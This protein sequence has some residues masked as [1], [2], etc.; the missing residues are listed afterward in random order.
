MIENPWTKVSKEE[1]YDNPWIK[2]T[3]HQVINAAGKAGIYG[4]V[5]FKNL[6]IGI[7]PVDREGYS[8]LVG[9]Y[10]FPLEAYSWEIPEGGGK[11]HLPPL[12][13]AKR[14][15]KEETGITASKWTE[16]QRIHTSNS[17]SDELGIIYLAEDLEI[18]KAE[19]DEDEVLEIKKIH[20]KEMLEMVMKGEITDSLSVAGILK[21]AMINSG[22]V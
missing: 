22:L 4:T 7:I 17:V 18:G 19:P 21:L 8:Y 5:H 11:L 20:W 2:V 15:L 9:Q 13:S 10:R 6:A 16:I 12:E 14:E 3:E 1:K